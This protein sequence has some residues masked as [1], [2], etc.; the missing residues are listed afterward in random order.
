MIKLHFFFI[1]NRDLMLKKTCSNTINYD[2][3]PCEIKKKYQNND[4]TTNK[5]F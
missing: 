4:R 1:Y 3:N 2:K 5:K